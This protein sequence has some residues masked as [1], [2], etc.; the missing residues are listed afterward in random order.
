MEGGQR[1]G[2]RFVAFE[3]QPAVCPAR[4]RVLPAAALEKMGW[5]ALNWID[6]AIWSREIQ[7]YGDVGQGVAYFLYLSLTFAYKSAGTGDLTSGIWGLG[8]TQ[9]R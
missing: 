9:S 5:H 7:V 4:F 8:I 1:D 2:R 3:S 6:G